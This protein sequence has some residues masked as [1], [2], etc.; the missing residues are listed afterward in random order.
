MLKPVRNRLR[1]NRTKDSS[2]LE[3]RQAKDWATADKLR[4]ELAEQRIEIRDLV[5][6]TDWRV[7]LT[8]TA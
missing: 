2:C 5:D 4:D 3:A 8:E 1:R 6:S 7:R